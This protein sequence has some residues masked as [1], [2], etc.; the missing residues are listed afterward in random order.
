MT[1]QH[2]EEASDRVARAA[3]L[4]DLRRIIGALF[5][6]YG[7]ILTVVGLTDSDAEID[8]AAGIQIN[9]WT[10]LSMLV[11]AAIFIGWA[12]MRPLSAELEE[13]EPAG[14]G[15]GGDPDGPGE[16]GGSRR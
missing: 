10:G 1:N 6:V 15:P 4:F 5:V 16:Q 8:K 11:V 13:S 7:L 14:G 2:G 9:L 12:L 3:N